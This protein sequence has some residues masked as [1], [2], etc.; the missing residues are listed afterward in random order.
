MNLFTFNSEQTTILSCLARCRAAV[1]ALVL[2]AV[3]EFLFLS[4]AEPLTGLPFLQPTADDAILVAKRRMLLDPRA[5]YDLVFIGDSSCGAGVMPEVVNDYLGLDAVNAGTVASFT[6][7]GYCDMINEMLETG[8]LPRHCV[9][10]VLPR[11]FSMTRAD[12]HRYGAFERYTLAYG[13]PRLDF[14]SGL[15]DRWQFFIRRHSINRFPPEIGGSYQAF[16]KNLADTNGWLPEKKTFQASTRREEQFKLDIEFLD[17]LNRLADRAAKKG[18]RLRV[19][20]SPRPESIATHKYW[21]DALDELKTASLEQSWSVLDHGC[22]IWPDSMFGSESHLT[23]EG[24][25]RFS[26]VLS[27]VLSDTGK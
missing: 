26:L 23:P 16:A 5:A 27:K 17:P 3:C 25:K 19:C 22:G 6:L 10:T 14:E 13:R 11:A 21:Q 4:T 15:S 7:P 12:V 18:C 1:A 9:I 20:L 2:I 8:H 24:A